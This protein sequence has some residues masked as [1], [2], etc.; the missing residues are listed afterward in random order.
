MTNAIQAMVHVT[1]LPFSSA[2]G[3]AWKN[4]PSIAPSPPLLLPY[5]NAE[6]SPPPPL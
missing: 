4:G 3:G 5:E 1:L 6:R 2:G